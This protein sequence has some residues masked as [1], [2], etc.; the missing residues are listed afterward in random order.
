MKVKVKAIIIGASVLAVGATGSVFALT[1]NTK[2]PAKGST[3]LDSVVSSADTKPASTQSAQVSTVDSTSTKPAAQQTTTQATTTPTPT[4]ASTPQPAY[5]QDSSNGNLYRVFD[6]TSVMNSAGIDSAQ[7]SDAAA[8]ISA[9]NPQWIY[10]NSDPASSPNGQYIGAS[11]CNAPA[12]RLNASVPDWKTS[13]IGQLQ[14]CNQYAIGRYG[15]WAAALSH[16]KTSG[17]NSF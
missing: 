16:I 10:Y 17:A 3:H 14:Y 13:P 6:Q 2:T 11:L 12:A 5:G 8:T 1:S 9:L 7:Q 4:P 15:S